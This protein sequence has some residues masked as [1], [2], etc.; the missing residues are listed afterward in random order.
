VA[1]TDTSEGES[2]GQGESIEY[3]TDGSGYF[4]MSERAASPYFLRRVARQ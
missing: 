1:L 4:T 3:E 2:E